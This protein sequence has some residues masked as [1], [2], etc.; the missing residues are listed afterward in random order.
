MHLQWVRK[1]HSVGPVIDTFKALVYCKRPVYK[2]QHVQIQHSNMKS[3]L[4]NMKHDRVEHDIV[5]SF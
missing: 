4:P 3:A 1:A 2:T 5:G